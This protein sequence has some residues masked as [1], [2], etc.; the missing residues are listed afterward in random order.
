MLPLLLA[1]GGGALAHHFYKRH[2]AQAHPLAPLVPSLQTPPV[3][4]HALG[5][6]PPHALGLP[7]MP[8]VHPPVPHLPPGI[9]VPK[10]IL[11]PA[12]AAIHGELMSQC[13]D[14][15]KLARAAHL[16]GAEGL[17]YHAQA[18]QGKAE[19]LHQ[20]V[21]GAQSIVE[22]CRSG[23]QHAMAIA[24]S[25]GDQAR[26]GN[27]RAQVSAWLIEEYTKRSPA[28]KAAA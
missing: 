22:R 28:K 20:M 17:P 13:V 23:D 21:Q 8:G 4:P 6:T 24:K 2:Q 18:L 19:M 1:L 3:P 15:Q 27:K 11:T 7:P 9:P 12:R 14:P 10:G 16:F 5:L 25:I 26:Q